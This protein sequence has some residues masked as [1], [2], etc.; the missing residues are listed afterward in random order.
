M[1]SV[2]VSRKRFSQIPSTF[3]LPQH[4]IRI[5][6]WDVLGDKG[7]HL[8][9]NQ[10][11]R[12]QPPQG[13]KGKLKPS[14]VQPVS[15]K[16]LTP[17][18]RSSPIQSSNHWDHVAHHPTRPPPP[19][20]PRGSGK[21]ELGPLPSNSPPSGDS[22]VIPHRSGWEQNGIGQKN[23][24]PQPHPQSHFTVV[25]HLGQAVD[26]SSGFRGAETEASCRQKGGLC[27]DRETET[28]AYRGQ[29]GQGQR[30]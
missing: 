7:L 12:S 2:K 25:S 6:E 15:C 1:L 21:T 18:Q 26:Y 27:T 13:T 20:A 3:S 23:L 8:G 4:R 17:A 19:G 11:I 24:T 22:A 16:L 10:S 29:R 5:L 9:R 30:H 14:E 28:W